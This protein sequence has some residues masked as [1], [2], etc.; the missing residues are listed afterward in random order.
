MRQCGEN[1]AVTIQMPMA[2]TDQTAAPK[3]RVET[4]ARKWRAVRIWWS[5]VTCSFSIPT[6]VQVSGGR[7]GAGVFL[8]SER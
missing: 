7:Y 3:K 2:V 1:V 6:V 5:F 8:Q 4:P